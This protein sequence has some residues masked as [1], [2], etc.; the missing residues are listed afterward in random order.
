MDY[1]YKWK[2]GGRPNRD[3]AA[4]DGNLLDESQFTDE[5]DRQMA[6]ENARRY[7]GVP[8]QTQDAGKSILPQAAPPD[9][10]I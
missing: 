4:R 10:N 3:Q 7:L 2:N 6:E 8:I 9:S 5:K 1:K